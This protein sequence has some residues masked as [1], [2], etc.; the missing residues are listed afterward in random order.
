MEHSQVHATDY[1]S[2]EP[3]INIINGAPSD[4]S[5]VEEVV[6]WVLLLAEQGY[7]PLSKLDSILHVEEDLLR[8]IFRSI[9]I[10]DE[11]VQGTVVLYLKA[12]RAKDH[13]SYLRAAKALVNNPVSPFCLTKSSSKLT[14]PPP[15]VANLQVAA[16]SQSFE[17]TRSRAQAFARASQLISSYKLPIFE[18]SSEAY[19]YLEWKHDVLDVCNTE[20][21][22][23]TKSEIILNCLSANTRLALL[24]TVNGLPPRETFDSILEQLDK[25]FSNFRSIR[26]IESSYL[27]CRITENE[28]LPTFHARFSRYARLYESCRKTVLTDHDK[29]VAFGSGLT[30]KYTFYV[31]LIETSNGSMTFN[32]FSQKLM[33]LA[34]ATIASL[35][36][37]GADVDGNEAEF[38]QVDTRASKRFRPDEGASKQQRQGLGCYRCQL[39]N[40]MA[41]ECT[42]KIKD[43]DSRCHRC[44]SR[45][46]LSSQ[47]K[48]QIKRPCRR[49]GGSQHFESICP[50]EIAPLGKAKPKV[51][52]VEN[53]V[54]SVHE[55]EQLKAI[56]EG[57]ANVATIECEFTEA[58][59]IG[60]DSNC[61][62]VTTDIVDNSA[63]LLPVRFSA[64][65]DPISGLADTGAAASFIAVCLVRELVRKKVIYPDDVFKLQPPIKIRF[66]NGHTFQSDMALRSRVRVKPDPI[67]SVFVICPDLNPKLIVGRPL[68]KVLGLLPDCT[69]IA[70]LNNMCSLSEER[71]D[72]DCMAHVTMPT[73]PRIERSA[74]APDTADSSSVVIGSEKSAKSKEKCDSPWIEVQPDGEKKKLLIR[75][76]LLENIMTEPLREPLRSYSRNT[77]QIILERFLA[78]TSEGSFIECSLEDIKVVTPIVL[79]DKKPQKPR[80]FP[81]PEVHQRYRITFDLRGYNRLQLHVAGDQFVLIPQ[82]LSAIESKPQTSDVGQFQR[83]SFE[84]L[85]KIPTDKCMFFSK[86]DI[87]NAYNSV[88]LPPNMQHI[89]TELYDYEKG[90]YRYF[91]CLTL[92]QGW[93]YSPTFFRMCAVY[94]VEQCRRN[95][96]D[97]SKYVHIDFFQ[98]DILIS[99]NCREKLVDATSIAISTLQNHRLTIRQNKVIVAADEV[100]FCGYFLKNQRCRP[101]P[102]RRNLHDLSD[103]MWSSF[104]SSYPH[105]TD[106]IRHWLRSLSGMT[107]Y[108]YGFLGPDELKCLQDLYALSS[109]KQQVASLDTYESKFRTLVSYVSNG[110]PLL[111]LGRFDQKIVCTVIISDANGDAWSSLVLKIVE[112]DSNATESPQLH[113]ELIKALSDALELNLLR[114]AIIP[115]RIC[116][117]RFLMNMRKQSSTHRERIACLETLDEV[118]PLLE[119]KVVLISDNRNCS[120]EWHQIDD[121][122][123]KHIKMWSR[124][125]QTVTTTLWMPRDSYPRLADIVARMISFELPIDPN[126]ASAAAIVT[127]KASI[128]PDPI[129]HTNPEV[130]LK[131][132]IRAAYASDRTHLNNVRISAIHEALK[133]RRQESSTATVMDEEIERSMKLFEIGPDDLLWCKINQ[134]FR[135]Y[136]PEGYS[137]KLP[138]GDKSI[139]IGLLLQA[140]NPG[141]IHV[142]I[143][144]TAYGCR[145]I[146]WPGISK[147]LQ[148]LVKGCW[149]CV[150]ERTRY[151]KPHHDLNFGSTTANANRPFSAWFIDHSGP[152]DLPEGKCYYLFVA[153]CGFSRFCHA[154][155]VESVDAISTATVLFELF[156]RFGIPAWIHSDKGSAFT[157]AVDS[158]LCKLLKIDHRFSPTGHP[159]S[160]GVCERTI[161]TLKKMISP[162]NQSSSSL[163]SAVSLAVYLQN[164]LPYSGLQTDLTPYE[165]VFGFKG[166]SISDIYFDPVQCTQSFSGEVQYVLRQAYSFYRD[167]ELAER[168]ALLATN[169]D[170][171]FKP[172][173]VVVVVKPGSG[174]RKTSTFGPYILLNLIGS[175]I[176]RAFRMESS[177]SA[178]VFEYPVDWLKHYKPIPELSGTTFS[179]PIANPGNATTMTKNDLFLAKTSPTAV[180]LF[181]VISVDRDGE[182]IFC[183]V[184]R[185]N[186]LLEFFKTEETCYVAF[187][188]VIFTKIKL[189]ARTIPDCVNQVAAQFFKR[190]VMI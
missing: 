125:C 190:G 126:S 10:V 163:R 28:S 158:E 156:C 132:D 164:C 76:P 68:L 48:A 58:V 60:C 153:V 130:S 87:A 180:G 61:N 136:I 85:R 101:S 134:K 175:R 131:D 119:G 89:G 51:K 92:S 148:S 4:D 123:A 96:E 36:T 91:K 127:E 9:D 106:G 124:Y 90:C 54:A 182:R 6:S 114:T 157:S 79:V 107:Q 22:F 21:C 102:T 25:L 146:W 155:I 50:K 187:A 170:I 100:T 162:S 174:I 82:C 56:I 185:P 173:D 3:S 118:Y 62:S 47:C 189:S 88:Y 121:L 154:C 168:S 178:T 69:R 171:N 43:Y 161:G 84:I 94:L 32:E 83:S 66:G 151:V 42:G 70:S 122:G 40:H 112:S 72:I 39:G 19:K 186:R 184:W 35:N 31:G 11:D 109:D 99:A 108:L 165:I 103:K 128:S 167:S 57:D 23:L 37:T 111:C 159:Q 30:K 34:S 97:L 65:S 152:F 52:F 14:L 133:Q 71:N 93:K 179:P 86:I 26:H 116:G 143:N 63:P 44:G 1:P 129:L 169:P 149:T 137:D 5:I 140:H 104:L 115:V 55:F 183:A 18:D 188:M 172:G 15:T 81:D 95:F 139:R 16:S 113:T 73:E 78:M 160:N 53:D 135:L 74:V 145:D 24:R 46:H 144:R 177:S 75:F 12:K 13:L 49:C 8:A 38:S 59:T 2:N 7:V 98:D 41:L 150:Q 166:R 77:E 80:V 27:T 67:D 45:K 147:D 141:G 20:E 176:W 105:D 138:F 120:K 64:E 33:Y 117:K 142:G 17:S 181:Q 29:I 110:L